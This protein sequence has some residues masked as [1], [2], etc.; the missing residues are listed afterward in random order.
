MP[1]HFFILPP[2]PSFV[3]SS[4]PSSPLSVSLSYASTTFIRL[5]LWCATLLV[6]TCVPPTTPIG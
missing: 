4:N 3:C 1:P 2:A 5:L 6:G